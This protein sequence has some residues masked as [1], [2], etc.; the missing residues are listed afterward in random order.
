VVR[1][2]IFAFFLACATFTAQAEQLKVG[3]GSRII[4][5]ET[6][7]W[8]AGY[9]SRSSPAE[10]TLHDLYAKVLAF[11]DTS[12]TRSLLITTDLVSVSADFSRRLVAA[13]QARHDIRREHIMITSSHTHCG[14]VMLERHMKIYGLTEEEKE[15]I[16]AYVDWLSGTILEAVEGAVADL[17]PASLGW[18]IGEATFAGNRRSHTLDGVRNAHNPIGVVDHDVPVLVVHGPENKVRAVLFGYACHNTTLSIQEYNGDY[19]GFAQIEI[20][21][22]LPNATALFVAGCAGDQNPY[23]RREIAYAEKHGAE[24]AEAVLSTISSGITPVHGPIHAAFAEIPLELSTP[25]TRDEVERQAESDNVYVQRRAAHLL[26]QFEKHGELQ[27]HYP[28]PVQVWRFADTLQLTAL[29]G[30][31]VVDYSLRLKHELGRDKH[32]VIAYAN[33]VPAYIPSLRVLREG[34]YEGKDAMLYYL[35]HGPWAPTIEETIVDA[36]H[37]LT[38]EAGAMASEA[39]A[40]N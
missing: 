17:A 4:T 34:G 11:E 13:I 27:T 36:V 38:E 29:G 9:A 19:A 3:V 37:A 1:N 35:M 16:A 32:F 18:G 7:V 8:M 22:A 31:V 20:E 40:E 30:E 14:P 28:Y 23:P 5:P 26:K 24:L 33:D 39:L 6:P 15:K 21:A 12:G 25:P 2:A 10:G